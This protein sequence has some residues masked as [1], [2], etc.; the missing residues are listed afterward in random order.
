MKEIKKEKQN[1]QRK[2]DEEFEPKEFFNQEPNE[3]TLGRKRDPLN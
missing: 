1:P 2:T 3:K